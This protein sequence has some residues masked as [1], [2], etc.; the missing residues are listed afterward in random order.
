MTE[1]KEVALYQFM[2]PEE[3]AKSL[4]AETQRQKMIDQ[5][6]KANLKNKVDYGT[7]DMK[8]KRKDGSE[9]TVTSKPSL[10]KPGSEKMLRLF[11]L[12]AEFEKDGATAEMYKNTVGSTFFYL[13]RLVDRSAGAVVGEGRGACS[14]EERYGNVNAALK[15]AEKRAQVDA[16]LRT[17]AL[18]DRFTQDLE[19]IPKNE[20]SAQ[21]G[22]YKKQWQPYQ[23]KATP[24]APSNECEKCAALITMKVAIFSKSKYGKFLCMNCQKDAKELTLDDDPLK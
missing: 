24:T 21:P 5:Y 18:S 22:A 9:Y 3:M 12:R 7:I 14:V 19:D 6:I 8:K 16:V 1:A 10:F 11:N 20:T 2:A 15:I 13:C 23:V 17:F 4:L